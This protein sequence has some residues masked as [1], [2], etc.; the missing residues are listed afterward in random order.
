VFINTPE[1]PFTI[2]RNAGRIYVADGAIGVRI[3]GTR[4]NAGEFDLDNDID[5]A[6]LGGFQQALTDG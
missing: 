6:D 1:S 3:F 4:S 2:V 5:E